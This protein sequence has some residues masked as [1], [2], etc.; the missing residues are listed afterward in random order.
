MA[1]RIAPLLAAMVL[2]LGGRPAF[3]NQCASLCSTQLVECRRD[4]QGDVACLRECD[5]SKQLCPDICKAMMKGG[6]D[7]KAV[8]REVLKVIEREENR[9]EEAARKADEALDKAHH[10][11]PNNGMH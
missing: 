1:L 10:H 5:E 9:R 6:N 8:Q 11:G 7:P 2:L 3:A 4:C